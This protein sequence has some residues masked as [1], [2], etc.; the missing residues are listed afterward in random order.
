M[1]DL[2]LIKTDEEKGTVTLHRSY[3]NARA[4]YF[5]KLYKEENHH[6]TAKFWYGKYTIYK[7]LYIAAYGDF[8][9]MQDEVEKINGEFKK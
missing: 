1:S 2:D 8:N 7:E 6:A 3:L 4:I 5:Y 9:L